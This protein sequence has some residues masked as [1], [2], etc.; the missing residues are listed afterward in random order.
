MPHESTV[1]HDEHLDLNSTEGGTNGPLA[2]RS[3]SKFDD[4][5]GATTPPP[6]TENGS[7]TTS[8]LANAPTLPGSASQ[9]SLSSTGSGAT[10]S[11]KRPRFNNERRRESLVPHLFAETPVNITHH[12]DE[13][14]SDEDSAENLSSASN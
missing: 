5:L 3:R 13:D 4:L 7:T 14:D 10:D 6:P 9:N 1:H 11:S 2:T 8:P 12:H